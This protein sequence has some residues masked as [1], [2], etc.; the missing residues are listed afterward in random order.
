MCSCGGSDSGDVQQEVAKPAGKEP[1]SCT[2]PSAAAAATG[3]GGGE[4]GKEEAVHNGG[5]PTAP[6]AGA[7]AV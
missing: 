4:V 1:P 6:G 7:D 2:E 3:K 5:K